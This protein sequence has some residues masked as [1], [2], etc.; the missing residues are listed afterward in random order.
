MQER[1]A[2]L[3]RATAAL[4]VPPDQLAD[5]IARLQADSKRLSRE[6]EQLKIKV[7]LGGGA[8]PSAARKVT[9]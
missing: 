1:E 5:A 7:A 2:A 6:N 9:S 3:A 8:S 4:G